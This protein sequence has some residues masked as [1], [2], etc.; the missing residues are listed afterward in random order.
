[1]N[2][3]IANSANDQNVMGGAGAGREVRLLERV[4]AV[5]TGQQESPDEVGEV[6]EVNRRLSE[7]EGVKLMRELI[8]KREME[9]NQTSSDLDS[10]SGY[11]AG[12]I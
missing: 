8:R 6:E 9:D 5:L 7:E 4:W 12:W 11:P 2:T 10:E 1:M 3:N